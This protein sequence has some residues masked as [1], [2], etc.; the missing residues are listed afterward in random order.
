MNFTLLLHDF[1]LFNFDHFPTGLQTLLNLSL[2]IYICDY[3]TPQ[4]I[5]TAHAFVSW[6]AG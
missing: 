1:V 5:N 4:H 6:S 3:T 2:P